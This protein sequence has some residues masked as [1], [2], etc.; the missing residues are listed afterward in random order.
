MLAPA[1]IQH[2]RPPAVRSNRTA[3]GVARPRPRR[4]LAVMELALRLPGEAKV[5]T[6]GA[7]RSDTLRNEEAEHCLTA[8]GHLGRTPRRIDHGSTRRT[9]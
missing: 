9:D 4:A 1:A 8:D 5:S 7:Y 2:E 3:T 6:A